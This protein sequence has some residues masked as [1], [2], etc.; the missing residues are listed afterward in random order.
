M[1]EQTIKTTMN[2]SRTKTLYKEWKRTCAGLFKIYAVGDPVI[3][4]EGL[5]DTF[6]ACPK[7]GPG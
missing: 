1:Y 7:L 2:E 5:P 4:R 3:K 6:C